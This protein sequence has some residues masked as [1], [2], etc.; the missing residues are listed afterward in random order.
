MMDD[1]RWTVLRL[2]ISSHKQGAFVFG[3]LWSTKALIDHL[4]GAT[5]SN[6]KFHLGPSLIFRHSAC[7]LSNTR[8]CLLLDLCN[9]PDFFFSFPPPHLYAWVHIRACDPGSTMARDVPP[10]PRLIWQE[11]TI[12]RSSHMQLTRRREGVCR[13]R[14]TLSRVYSLLWETNR[15]SRFSPCLRIER[16]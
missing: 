14:N 5:R 10:E 7:G 13:E 8:F 2:L 3:A 4:D 6:E 1:V 11:M 16:L 12:S 9:A 15:L